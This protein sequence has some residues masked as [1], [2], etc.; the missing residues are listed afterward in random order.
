MGGLVGSAINV[1]FNDPILDNF[2]TSLLPDTSA[3]VKLLA[4]R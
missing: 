1:E 2:A 3:L 4:T